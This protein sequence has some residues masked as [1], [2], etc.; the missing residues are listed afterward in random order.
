VWIVSPSKYDVNKLFHKFI[1]DDV[2]TN[3]NVRTVYC[4][5]LYGTS[6]GLRT[7]TAINRMVI[8]LLSTSKLMLENPVE[9]VSVCNVRR[10]ATVLAEAIKTDNTNIF[11]EQLWSRAPVF[12]FGS[13]LMRNLNPQE[14]GFGVNFQSEGFLNLDS[15]CC[16]KKDDVK[17]MEL[18]MEEIKEALK[19]G[20]Q[21]ELF[22]GHYDNE[23]HISA[24]IKGYS[25]R[26]M[27]V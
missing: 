11:V 23:F 17:F 10:Y 20:L 1:G 24:M 18:F 13:I 25:Y 8:E 7:D 22:S 6:R 12:V 14:Y 9:E 3:K 27:Y 5:Q 21:E 26:G 4:P 16:V 2:S 19:H 15:H